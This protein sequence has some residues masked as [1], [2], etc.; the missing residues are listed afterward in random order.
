[1]TCIHDTGAA[2]TVTSDAY[3]P[4]RFEWA[5]VAHARKYESSRGW[6]DVCKVRLSRLVGSYRDLNSLLDIYKVELNVVLHQKAIRSGDA[7]CTGDLPIW[8]SKRFHATAAPRHQLVAPKTN[9]T[10]M[11]S[12]TTVL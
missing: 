1:M 12:L 2:A 9:T 4:L 11:A 3:G 6:Q 8:M 7:G 10:T 5:Q